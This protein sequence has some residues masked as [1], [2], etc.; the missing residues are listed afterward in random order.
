MATHARDRA[1]ILT[2]LATGFRLNK[3]REV[4]LTDVHIERP[5]ERSYLF[6]RRRRARAPQSVVPGRPTRRERGESVHEGLRR[7]AAGAAAPLFDHRISN[8]NAN[9]VCM[10]RTRNSHFDQ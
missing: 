5:L 9:Q 2:F 3:L 8:Q 1:V 4:R 7:E 10:S 6:V